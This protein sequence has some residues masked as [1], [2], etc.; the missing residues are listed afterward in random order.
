MGKQ[1]AAGFFRLLQA[2]NASSINRIHDPLRS[3][4]LLTDEVS[5]RPCTLKTAYKSK[6]L[7]LT[8]KL[9]IRQSRKRNQFQELKI[10]FIEFNQCVKLKMTD[11]SHLRKPTVFS[12]ADFVRR[13]RVNDRPEKQENLFSGQYISPGADLIVI[14][15]IKLQRAQGGCLGTKSR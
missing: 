14:A 5:V 2:F 4:T 6:I 3:W 8:Q 15:K 10:N 12:V 13:L 7:F 1:E 9:E 11:R